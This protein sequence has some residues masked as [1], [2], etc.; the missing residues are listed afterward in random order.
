MAGGAITGRGGVWSG[1]CSPFRRGQSAISVLKL[2]A[3]A[4]SCRPDGVPLLDW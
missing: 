4:E 2:A 1:A 3:R